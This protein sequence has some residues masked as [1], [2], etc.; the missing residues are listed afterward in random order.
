ME[1][2]YIPIGQ[3]P[4]RNAIQSSGLIRN[5][6]SSRIGNPIAD[7]GKFASRDAG[8]VRELTC[9]LPREFTSLTKNFR[10]RCQVRQ[11]NS[12]CAFARFWYTL[13]CP[14]N[15]RLWEFARINC[16]RNS[17]KVLFCSLDLT[18]DKLILFQVG[19]E[20]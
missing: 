4:R 1:I 5:R 14:L 20:D 9:C 12:T 3:K 7:F 8:A 10:T 13:L 16:A 11:A 17:G 2:E 15:R 18:Q 19:L 6:R